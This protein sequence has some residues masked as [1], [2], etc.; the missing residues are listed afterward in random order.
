MSRKRLAKSLLLG[1]SAIVNAMVAQKSCKTAASDVDK[2][3]AKTYQILTHALVPQLEAIYE[4]IQGSA[5][6]GARASNQGGWFFPGEGEGPSVARVFDHAAGAIS[7]ARRLQPLLLGLSRQAREYFSWLHA[8]QLSLDKEE[9]P[10]SQVK[11]LLQSQRM[12]GALVLGNRQGGTTEV[13]S[14]ENRADAEEG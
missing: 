12:C 9:L 2:A 10:H 1:Y 14:S 8:S 5:G 13:A 11:A 3:L 6:A 7:L 4:H